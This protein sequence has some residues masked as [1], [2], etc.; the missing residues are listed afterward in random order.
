MRR[1]RKVLPARPAPGASAAKRE[2]GVAAA[3]V[4]VAAEEAPVGQAAPRVAPLPAAVHHNPERRV[5]LLA[6]V[7]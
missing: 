6:T 4:A 1:S 3:A 5:R 7:P 2:S